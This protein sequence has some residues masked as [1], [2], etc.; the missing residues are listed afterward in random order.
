MSQ[1]KSTLASFLEPTSIVVGVA[2]LN[3][4]VIWISSRNCS[5]GLCFLCPWYCPW[6]YT[7]APT[8]LFLA[9]SAV[10]FKKWL[11]CFVGVILSAFVLRSAIPIGIYLVGNGELF[12]DMREY[13]F[14]FPFTFEGQWLL[15]LAVF[16]LGIVVFLRS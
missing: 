6:T 4:I 16:L 1:I 14:R 9:A 12:R 13:T 15:A 11:G 8:L 2:L 5:I 7:N 3:F 10:R